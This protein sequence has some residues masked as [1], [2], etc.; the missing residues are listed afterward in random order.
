MTLMKKFQYVGIF[1]SFIV[2]DYM[3]IN[4]SI[5]FSDVCFITINTWSFAE[6]NKVMLMLEFSFVFNGELSR[7]F[8]KSFET[9][10]RT[11]RSYFKS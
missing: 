7:D 9:G 8:Y 10:Q 2:M 3:F 11:W 5:N 6:I 1:V 4:F